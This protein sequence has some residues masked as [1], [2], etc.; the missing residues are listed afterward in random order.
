MDDEDERSGLLDSA[1]VDDTSREPTPEELKEDYVLFSLEGK[2]KVGEMCRFVIEYEPETRFPPRKSL[3]LRVNNT[4]TGALIAA[5]L[6]GPFTLY[7]DCRPGSWREDKRVLDEEDMPKYDN[8]VRAGQSFNCELKIKNAKRHTW[9]VDVCSDVMFSSTASVGFSI[10]VATSK[11]K[12]KSKGSPTA[13]PMASEFRVHVL[14]TMALWSSPMPKIGRPLHLVVLTHGLVS[15]VTADL[16]YIKEQIDI[17]AEKTGQSIICKGYT[18]NAGKTEKGIKKQ[19]RKLADWIIEELV[20][21]YHPEKMSFV[22]HSLGGVVQ[23]YALGYIEKTIP[24][25]FSQ[26]GIELVNFIAIAS[27]FLGIT[28]ENPAYVKMALEFGVV[29]KSG[30]DLGM[31]RSLTGRKPILKRLPFGPSHTVISRFKHR[32]LYANAVN[33]GIVPL[34]TASLLYLDWR[35]IAKASEAKSGGNAHDFKTKPKQTQKEDQVMRENDPKGN[36]RENGD[37]RE[38]EE[39]DEKAGLLSNK[40][41]TWNPFTNPF[42]VG[43]AKAIKHSQTSTNGEEGKHEKV[44]KRKIRLPKKT[45]LL[46]SGFSAFMPPHPDEKFISNPSVRDDVIFHDRVYHEEDL[47]PRRF[48]SKL[49]ERDAVVEQARSEEKLARAWHKGASWRKVLV[50]LLPDAHNNIVVRRR[51]SN[52]YGWP[53]VHHLVRNHFGSESLPEG[54]ENDGLVA[55]I[56]DDEEIDPNLPKGPEHPGAYLPEEDELKQYYD[57]QGEA[58]SA[59]YSS[60][61]SVDITLSLYDSSV[62]SPSSLTGDDDL[63]QAMLATNKK[64]H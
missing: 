26:W 18:G 4:E 24:D 48:R 3:W 54:D 7:V 31:S 21:T 49:F 50:Q 32:T 62:E 12:C 41:S 40:M 45:S 51:F 2:Q 53:V 64:D 13:D 25:F 27:P 55:E 8:N 28:S 61:A 36:L 44:H 59:T 58:D 11:A 39:D 20:P 38:E 17:M 15:N 16:F 6:N 10:A 23:S 5:Y 42:T 63:N 60:T 52:A 47:P 9:I 43:T 14:D 35:A 22:A 33:D 57:A 19:G 46:E 37:P 1:D 56:S 30:R 29:G 34:R